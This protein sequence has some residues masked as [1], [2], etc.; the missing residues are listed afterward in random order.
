MEQFVL[1][2]HRFLLKIYTELTIFNK[3]LAKYIFRC[4]LETSK[5]KELKM[6]RNSISQANYNNSQLSFVEAV[7]EYN[8]A[9]E[10]L[11]KSMG[12]K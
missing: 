2:P 7:F 6:R 10:T 1:Q 12:M 8:V 9:R 5:F 11:L 3:F 4:F